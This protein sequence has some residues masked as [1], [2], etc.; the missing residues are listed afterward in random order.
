M[1]CKRCGKNIENNS[2]FCGYCGES[3]DSFINQVQDLEQSLN[4]KNLNSIP[5]QPL[6]IPIIE[7]QNTKSSQ[8]QEITISDNSKQKSPKRNN[9]ALTVILLI[10]II[11]IGVLC[12]FIFINSGDKEKSGGN[13][14]SETKKS[15]YKIT[16]NS[17]QNFDLY[18]LQ[19]EN[20][21]ENKIYSPLSIKYALAML[22]EGTEGD[23]K[24]QISNVIGDYNAKKYVNSENMSFANAIFINEAYKNSINLEYSNTLANKYNAEVIFDSFKTTDN[25]NSWISEKTLKLIGGA[26][27]N[28][29]EETKFLLVNAL[30]IDMEW[31]QKFLHYKGGVNYSHVKFSWGGV[32]N[33]TSNSFKGNEEI[34]GMKIIASLNN[35]DIVNT[36]GEDKIRETVGNEFRKYLQDKSNWD[37]DQYLNGDYSEENINKV[38][39]E[40]LDR[41]IQE[42]NSNYKRVDKT[43]EFS[44]HVDENV[45]AFAKDLKEYNGTT[46]EYIAIMPQNEELDN[47]ISNIDAE[48]INKIT[49]NLKELK[50]ENFNDGVVTKITGFIP[51]FKFEYELNLQE[52]LKKLGITNIFDMSKANLKGITSEKDIFI[53]KVSHKANIEFTQDGIKAAAVTTIGGM[54]AG[55]S[56][57]YLYDVPVEEIDLT[58]DK[59]YMFII[60]D[61]QTGEVWFTGTV[62]NPLSWSEE[63]ENPSN[64]Y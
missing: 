12:A 5:Q 42:I 2:R 21:K 34:S 50:L 40:Y 4:D 64:K 45:K 23:S 61:K 59:P 37:V 46:L 7:P 11:A 35:Y 10:L 27:D 56:F 33:V 29:D 14:N 24:T 16:G 53:G 43:T 48:K 49:N 8:S 31:N 62:Y 30:G 3:I 28:L 18:F 17:L 58:F 54:G 57:D 1:I 39:N 32:E 19:L 13:I 51:K 52:D 36:L 63:P 55:G 15:K 26:L 9:N 25:I 38:V 22:N 60:R 41:Y 6:N 47:F 44:L 20:K